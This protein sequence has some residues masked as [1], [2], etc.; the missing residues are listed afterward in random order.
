MCEISYLIS[1]S[2][3]NLVGHNVFL[4]SWV[5]TCQTSWMLS[6]MGLAL[7][8]LLSQ[9]K[10][11]YLLACEHNQ[12]QFY[13]IYSAHVS[14]KIHISN[15]FN[16]AFAFLE[17]LHINHSQGVIL[18]PQTVSTSCIGYVMWLWSDGGHDFTASS[19]NTDKWS[20]SESKHE[21]K[22]YCTNIASDNEI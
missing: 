5:W 7:L 12:Y 10:P 9:Y 17:F 11:H 19:N 1:L 6:F 21:Q 2:S 8:A 16:S 14:N 22:C 18:P 4:Y 3:K 15:C 13:M 20:R